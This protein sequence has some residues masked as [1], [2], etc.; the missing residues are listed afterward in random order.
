MKKFFSLVLALVMALSLTTIAW[1]ATA[2]PAPDANGVITLTENVTLT[3]TGNPGMAIADGTVIDGA[4]YTLTLEGN[5]G[6]YSSGA[7]FYNKTADADIVVKN[8]KIDATGLTAG[9]IFDFANATYNNVDI[10]GG[11]TL[12]VMAAGDGIFVKDCEFIGFTG[13]AIDT[14]VS[15]NVVDIDTCVFTGADPANDIA[16]ILR[17]GDS[18]AVG[19]TFNAKLNL[20][21]DDV[22]E[23]VTGNTFNSRVKVY[24]DDETLTGNSFGTAGYIELDDATLDVD[25]SGNYWG[26]SA[27]T[28]AQLGGATADTYYTTNTA[29]TLSDMVSGGNKGTLYSADGLKTVQTT[30][31]DFVYVPAKAL[32]KSVTTGNVAHYFSATAGAG[33]VWMVVGAADAVNTDSILK[34]GGTEKYVRAVDADDVKYTATATEYKNIGEKCGQ[35]VDDGFGT[36]YYTLKDNEGKAVDGYFVEGTQGNVLLG[37]VVV[38]MATANPTIVDH[39]WKEAAYDKDGYC[40]ALKCENCPA[41]AKLYKPGTVPA[42]VVSEA[43]GYPVYELMVVKAPAAPSTDKV[44]SAETFDAG[45]AMYVGMSVM[46]AAGSAV[47]LKKRED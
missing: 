45:I 24:T 1:G 16:V 19:S 13:T 8:L 36:K 44:T 35:I 47:V 15:G 34:I 3:F 4:G 32:S 38:G 37:S 18:T 25:A 28:A 14:D 33:N 9:Y 43:S 6:S 20:V 21:A 27:P 11:S 5:V 41:T 17:N 30:G 42:G 12:I 10:T 26:G 22:A 40:N 23:N 29:G 39:V 31:D 7:A 46:A 2:L